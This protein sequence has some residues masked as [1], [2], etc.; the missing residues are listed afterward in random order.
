MNIQIFGKTK[1]FDT[2]KAERWFMERGV[3]FQSVDMAA[4]GMSRGELTSVLSTVGGLDKLIDADAKTPD[5][6][7]LKYLASDEA[8]IEKLLDTP[9]LFRTPI[10]RNGK[11][12][13]VGFCPAIWKNWT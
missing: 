6:L 7:L 5:A 11:E 9:K 12:A 13:T 1:C 4:K 3:K 8:K 10:V 2:R